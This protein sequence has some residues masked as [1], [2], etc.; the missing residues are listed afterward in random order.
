MI[1]IKTSCNIEYRK[2]SDLWNEQLKK[3]KEIIIENVNGTEIEVINLNDNTQMK[4]LGYW[5]GMGTWFKIKQISRHRWKDK[6]V[7]LS[8]KFGSIIVTPNHSILDIN[9]KICSPLENPFLL[10]IRKLNYNQK[11]YLNTLNLSIKGVYNYDRYY[12]WLNNSNKKIKRKLNYN[13]LK[14]LCR[15]ISAFVAEGHTSYNKSNKGYFVGISNQDKNWLIELE[16]DLKKFYTGTCCYIKHKKHNF[17]DVWELQ[18]NSKILYRFLRETCGTNSFCKQLPMWF[19]QLNKE[20][21]NIILQKLIEGDGC[22]DNNKFRYTTASYKLA[23]Q[24]SLLFSLLNYDYNVNEENKNNNIYYHFRQVD[25]YVVS[26]D[27]NGK[28]FELLDYDGWVYDITVD[29]VSNFAVGVGNIVVHNSHVHVS[30]EMPEYTA[31]VDGIGVLR[32]LNAVKDSGID[33]KIYQASTSEMFGGIPGSEPQNEFTPFYP[34]SPYAASKVFAY[35]ICQN[36]KESYNMFISNGILFNH[37]SPRRLPTFVT[38]KVTNGIAEIYHGKRD[39][40][41][42]GNIDSKRDWGHASDFVL[43]MHMILQHD[44]PDNFVVATGETHT[45]R[46]FIEKAFQIVEINI[47]WVGSG[48]NEKGF[49]RKTGKMLVQV[50]DRFFRPAEVDILQG[51][52]F[53]IRKTLGWYPTVSFDK[54]IEEMVEYDITNLET[55]WR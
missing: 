19:S 49:C 32:L 15:F 2:F 5:N 48:K 4:A 43:A 47:E 16:N 21:L 52:S 44:K 40:I 6:V 54:L 7:K 20:L 55:I 51:D 29:E 23:C 34:R 27:V 53:K 11:K 26:S 42:I 3:N 33:C 35:N 14:S 41:P 24:L 36:Y 12:F 25:S 1:P 17:K 45:V 50:E 8:Q 37:C 39:F 22:Y 46:E 9:Q 18:I 28:K 31:D 38:R 30:F 10:N 13:D